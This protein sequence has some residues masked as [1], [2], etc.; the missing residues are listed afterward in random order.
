MVQEYSEHTRVCSSFCKELEIQHLTKHSCWY[1][2]NLQMLAT[3]FA[4]HSWV[5]IKGHSKEMC[6]SLE[7][8]RR[9]WASQM[10]SDIGLR[11][12]QME[13]RVLRNICK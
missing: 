2:K 8:L 9:S 1:N 10:R 4:Q 6:K 13:N 7:L 11:H 12:M 3:L 5:L